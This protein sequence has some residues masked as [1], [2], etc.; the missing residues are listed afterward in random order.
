M[1]SSA[2]VLTFLSLLLL[3]ACHAS[4]HPVAPADLG[5]PK[6]LSALEALLDEPGPL[7]IESVASADWAVDRAGL[8]N[9][10]H[11]KAE[12]AHLESGPE[13]IHIYFH[14]VRHPEKGLFVIDSGVERNYRDDIDATALSWLVKQAMDPSTLR[15]KM[16]LRDYLERQNSPLRGVFL[17]HLHLDHIMG[18]P[19]VDDKVPLYTGPGEATSSH[20]THLLTRSSGDAHLAGK[21]ALRELSFG[22]GATGGLGKVLDLFGDGSLWAIWVPGHTPGSVAYLGRTTRGPVLVTGDACHTRWGWD[23]QVEPGT[24]SVDHESSVASLNVLEALVRRHPNIE[25]RLGHQE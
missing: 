14:S 5:Q 23:N 1:T 7:Q 21:H 19:D 10:D 13:P 24:F 17:T 4:S 16:P 15:V 11:P 9:L 3:P 6:N 20:W 22:T 18:I 25:V 8:I 12:A 2:R